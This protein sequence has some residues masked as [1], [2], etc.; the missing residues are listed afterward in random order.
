M[1]IN[2]QYNSTNIA[3]NLSFMRIVLAILLATTIIFANKNMFLV[4]FNIIIC[5]IACVSDYFDGYFARKYKTC[6]RIGAELD[7]AADKIL[8]ILVLFA[9]T[10]RGRIVGPDVIA[11]FVIIVRELLISSLRAT[12]IVLGEDKPKNDK[13][14]TKFITSSYA[15][16][17][18]TTFQ[19]ITLFAF[20]LLDFHILEYYL[21]IL[22]SLVLWISAILSA[23]SGLKY[24]TN[25]FQ[26][27]NSQ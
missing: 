7:P 15:A 11:L 23:I 5:T 12:T 3:N 9:L 1:G 8:I 25:I 10:Y 20:L 18:K 19:C 2:T 13:K 22:A 26:E 6:S 21:Q 27:M 24:I 17:L 14:S 4:I 16:K